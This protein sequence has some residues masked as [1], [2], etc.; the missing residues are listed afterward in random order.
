M[1]I[2]TNDYLSVFSLP[3][4]KFFP[5]RVI[6][7]FDD[8]H[9]VLN[10]KTKEQ[11]KTTK[12]YENNYKRFFLDDDLLTKIGFKKNQ[13]VFKE[14]V[15]YSIGLLDIDGIGGNIV[16]NNFKKKSYLIKRNEIPIIENLNN[17][18]LNKF[19]NA[20]AEIID[21][22]KLIKNLINEHPKVFNYEYFDK[23]LSEI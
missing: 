7:I 2:K 9:E 1:N 22:N 11:R 6:E 13:R 8:Y 19:L 14:F 16:V 23:L 15:L 3:K 10:L 4:E 5:A 18:E 17:D 12:I 21:V 20:K